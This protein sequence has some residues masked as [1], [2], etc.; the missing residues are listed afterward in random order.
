MFRFF[1]ARQVPEIIINESPKTLKMPVAP[2]TDLKV[3][4]ENRSIRGF[5]DV[6]SSFQNCLWNLFCISGMCQIFKIR[7]AWKLPSPFSRN[8]LIPTSETTS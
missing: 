5:F 3:F 1:P 4:Y 7:N 2:K 8:T 6:E